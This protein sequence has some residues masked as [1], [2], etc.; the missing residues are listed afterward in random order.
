MAMQA[1]GARG[2]DAESGPGIG[3]PEDTS[4]LVD[5]RIDV[6]VTAAVLAF[7]IAVILTSGGLRQGSIPDPIGPGGWPRLLGGVLAAVAAV[8]I[9]RRLANWRGAAGHLVPGDGGKD[10]APSIPSS[11]LRP[12]FLLAVGI[13][14]LAGVSSAGFVITT[15]A[16]SLASVALMRV[17][18][19]T[20]L[21]LTPFVFTVGIWALFGQVFGVRLPAGPIERFLQDI[22]PF[23][24]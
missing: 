8:L 6:A 16:A 2:P 9:V 7:A 18:V 11:G 19:W 3:A 14:W 23:L 1:E 20:K 10:D 22:L 4:G 5:R 13:G 21:F 17:R 12:Y 24:R 15:F